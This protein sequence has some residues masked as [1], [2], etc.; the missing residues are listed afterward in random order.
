MTLVILS[1]LTDSADIPH[2][3]IFVTP[4]VR[5]PERSEGSPIDPIRAILRRSFTA[6]RMTYMPFDRVNKNL[7]I[8][9]ARL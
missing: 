9:L 3:S 8:T 5:H 7:S 4:Q 1:F 2:R 6:F